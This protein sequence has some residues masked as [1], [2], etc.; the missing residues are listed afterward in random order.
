MTI[1][2]QIIH[3]KNATIRR[4]LMK[5]ILSMCIIPCLLICGM[6]SSFSMENRMMDVQK[7][8]QLLEKA[9]KDLYENAHY[10]QVIKT[11]AKGIKIA[12]NIH[13]NGTET[14]ELY[15]LKGE[16]HLKTGDTSNAEST[17]HALINSIP[18]DSP[19]AMIRGLESLFNLYLQ[20]ED[21]DKA[22]N[23]LEKIKDTCK[24]GHEKETTMTFHLRKANL[25]MAKGEPEKA[26]EPLHKAISIAED[27][28]STADIC[29][30]KS[31][32]WQNYSSTGEYQKAGT[33]LKEAM[34]A[35]DENKLYTDLVYTRLFYGSHMSN[36]YRFKE[37]LE[38]IDKAAEM[39]NEIR[40]L[41]GFI[42]SLQRFAKVHTYS[43]HADRAIPYLEKAHEMAKTYTMVSDLSNILYLYGDAYSTMGKLPEALSYYSDSSAIYKR[44]KKVDSYNMTLIDMGRCHEML[45]DYNKAEKQYRYVMENS[46]N[47]N[48]VRMA[49]HSL[50]SITSSNIPCE[51]TLNRLAKQFT[52]EK[53]DTF[54]REYYYGEMGYYC[55]LLGDYKTAREFLNKAE[56]LSGKNNNPYALFKISINRARLNIM[57]N[58][59]KEADR[60]LDK[61]F[62]CIKGRVMPVKYLQYLA[63]CCKLAIYQKKYNKVST[64]GKI[65]LQLSTRLQLPYYQNLFSS[66]ISLLQSQ[67]DYEE[68]KKGLLKSLHYFYQNDLVI[69][70]I[71]TTMLIVIM[72]A[73]KKKTDTMD[74]IKKAVSHADR[75]GYA[76]G[77]ISLKYTVLKLF[78]E[79]DK[80]TRQQY[81]DYLK[82]YTPYSFDREL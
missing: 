11:T 24:K 23:T 15:L 26:I 38:S 48:R 63:Q 16:A 25:H 41:P 66:Y 2:N 69:N 3:K 21:M 7:I 80:K 81:R 62:S 8:R 75:M 64:Y 18:D 51:E 39:S 27:S 40:F 4:S 59:L 70:A 35:A 53:T 30:L 12:E 60:N 45:G 44:L 33:Y 49:R 76:F 5:R 56:K 77:S 29:Y 10:P 61:A 22:A 74:E 57:E 79:M 1:C 72:D 31:M 37:A 32:I 55:T 6:V 47:R 71:D 68:G 36:M 28:D 43:G 20:L 13:Y 34:Q 54:S 78:P 19:E 46:M 14:I 52:R 42:M 67:T 9:Q 73:E 17:Y 82:D 50:Y 58:R 65:G